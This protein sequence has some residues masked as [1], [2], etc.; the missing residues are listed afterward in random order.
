MLTAAPTPSLIDADAPSPTRSAASAPRVQREPAT[1]TSPDAVDPRSRPG[2]ALDLSIN[3][4]DFADAY[5]CIEETVHNTYIDSVLPA[6][7]RAITYVH[8][9]LRATQFARALENVDLG[10]QV[11][12][13]TRRIANDHHGRAP[14]AYVKLPARSA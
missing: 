6:S 3:S 10:H 1:S 11:P 2:P 12:S 4:V 5:F 7:T 8:F 9:D 13:T 14:C